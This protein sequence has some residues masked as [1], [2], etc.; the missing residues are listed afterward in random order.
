MDKNYKE[1]FTWRELDKL[2]KDRNAYRE[3]QK[4][5]IYCEFE[6][7]GEHLTDENID[8]LITAGIDAIDEYDYCTPVAAG[9]AIRNLVY[10]IADDLRIEEWTEKEKELFNLYVAGIPEDHLNSDVQDCWIYGE[11]A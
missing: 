7:D 6:Y 9:N 2:I 5:T 1:T 8:K 4:F 3:M 10:H 11:Y